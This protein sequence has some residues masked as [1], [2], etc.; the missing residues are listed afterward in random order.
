MASPRRPVERAARGT[1]N[2]SLPDDI[3]DIREAGER[4]L[5]EIR[6][7]ITLADASEH[8]KS[9]LLDALERIGNAMGALAV[10]WA[11]VQANEAQLQTTNQQ[12]A[13]TIAADN[14][15]ITTLQQQ[16]ASAGQAASL[17]TD[18]ADVTAAQQIIA[19]GQPPITSTAAP[20]A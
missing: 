3:R 7:A 11:A 12:Q 9:R 1:L 6:R 8:K 16:L 4:E 5:N 14:T 2:M 13:A 10:G 19:A 20:G 15:Q 18:A 17:I